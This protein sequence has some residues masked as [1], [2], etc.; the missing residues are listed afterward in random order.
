[1]EFGFK[2]TTNGRTLLA[3]CAATGAGL[4]ITRVEVGQGMA[5]DGTDLA[6]VHQLY[7]YVA[8]GAIGDRKHEDDR[9]HLTVQYS[10]S[11]N[12]QQGSFTL[13]EFMIYAL[14]PDTEQETDLI[15]AS[16]GSY[17]QPVPMY[18]AN[19]QACVFSYPLVFV[20]SDEINVTV[21]VPAGLV[22]YD[23][24]ASAVREATRYFGGIVKAISFLIELEDWQISA[25]DNGYLYYADIKDEDITSGHVPAVVLDEAS[26]D[27]AGDI[28]MC[29]AARSYSGYVR[30]KAKLPPG[31]SISGML[32]LI[33]RASGGGGEPFMEIDP[34]VPN[35]AKEENKPA[36]NA[37]E[38]GALS[39]GDL[40]TSE[41]IDEIVNSIS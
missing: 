36:Y 21:E 24:L 5:P 16:L 20:L 14:D 31:E 39:A 35:W 41:E 8:D 33:G 23:D 29:A 40:I 22:T 1:M 2:I 18:D 9:L 34:T 28:Q 27:V 32:Y 13:S 17:S 25:D 3:A 6:D 37:N 12:P 10:N 7:D 38:V 19:L 4:T 15:Y 11:E 30:I 26:Q